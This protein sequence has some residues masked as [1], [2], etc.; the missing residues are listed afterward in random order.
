MNPL[1]L[2]KFC[3]LAYLLSTPGCKSMFYSEIS[4]LD[5]ADYGNA[6]NA[7]ISGYGLDYSCGLKKLAYVLAAPTP[8]PP[9][10]WGL[11]LVGGIPIFVLGSAIL[12]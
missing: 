4:A 2:V 6:E 12:L 8:G 7:F 10:L 5:P 3:L 11:T 9:L 1:F